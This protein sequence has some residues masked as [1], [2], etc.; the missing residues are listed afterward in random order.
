MVSQVNVYVFPEYILPKLQHLPYNPSPLIRATY[1]ECLAS[2]ADSSARFLQMAQAMKDNSSG[3]SADGEEGDTKAA[4]HGSFDSAKSDLMSH[5]QDHAKAFLTD[6]DPAVRRAFLRSVSRLC[7]FFGSQKANDIIL[8]HLNTYLN[9]KDWMLRCAFFE[10]IISVA[11]FV[12]GNSL[13]DF[14]LPLMVQA[15]TDPEEFVIEK[16]IHSLSAMAQLGLFQKAKMWELVDV[17]SRFSMHPN[18]W[19]REGK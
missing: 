14:I 3:T 18:L 2:L 13:E 15:L 6:T 11:T 1:A 7:V 12:G 10:T 5:F 17:V 19:I 4:Y 16:V 8:S 9:D